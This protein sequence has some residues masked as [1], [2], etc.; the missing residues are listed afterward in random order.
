MLYLQGLSPADRGYK[1]AYNFNKPD[2]LTRNYIHF[3]SYLS[4]RYNNMRD[5]IL[6]REIENTF[7]RCLFT[8]MNCNKNGKIVVISRPA[9]WNEKRIVQAHIFRLQVL[10]YS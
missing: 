10:Q 8:G 6:Q 5:R 7:I 4:E 3:K 1:D 9:F 2:F